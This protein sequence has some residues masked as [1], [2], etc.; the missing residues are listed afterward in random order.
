MW[1]IV[2]TSFC[3]FS[4][5][6]RHADLDGVHQ[7]EYFHHLLWRDRP[8]VVLVIHAEGP[9]TAIQMK[10]KI[11]SKY[12]S[13]VFKNIRLDRLRKAIAEHKSSSTRNK[14]CK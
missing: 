11:C 1:N 7:G 12:F 4:L 13:R 14:F 6:G 9:P 8:G 2:E 5:Q 10:F 3:A